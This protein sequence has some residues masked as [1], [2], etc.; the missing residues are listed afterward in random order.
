MQLVGLIVIHHAAM[1]TRILH[2]LTLNIAQPLHSNNIVTTQWQHICLISRP[3]VKQNHLCNAP[4][5]S[6]T[7]TVNSEV[8]SVHTTH[9]GNRFVVM[10]ANLH[11]G[12]ISNRSIFMESLSYAPFVEPW[13]LTYDNQWLM[14]Q[15]SPVTMQYSH[16]LTTM[17]GHILKWV[18]SITD[19]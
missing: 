17:C 14:N 3:E 8:I 10:D 9:M 2:E 12:K 19:K 11:L 6:P 13:C 16:V 5:K 4:P 15:C 18:E 1:Q 7:I